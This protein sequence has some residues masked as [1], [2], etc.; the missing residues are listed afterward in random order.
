MTTNILTLDWEIIKQLVEEN[1]NDA[2]LGEEIRSMY[3]KFERPI[4]VDDAGCD[5]KTGKFLG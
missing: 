5:V 4:V 2:K 1:P 3:H